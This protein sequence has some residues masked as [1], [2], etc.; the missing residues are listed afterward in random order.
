MAPVVIVTGASRA[1][2]QP[3]HKRL[4]KQVQMWC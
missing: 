1:W 3:R 4:Q 2:A